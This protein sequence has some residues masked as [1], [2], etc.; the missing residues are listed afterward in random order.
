[1]KS[2][3]AATIALLAGNQY[4]FAELYTITLV[5]NTIL[6][7]TDGDGPITFGGNIFTC[8]APLISRS[9]LKIIVGVQADS[10]NVM[11]KVSQA[12]LINGITFPQFAAN[13]GFDGAKIQIDR[14]Y[15][16]TYGD[17]SAGVVNIFT[18]IV[19]DV[20]PSRTEVGL[21]VNSNLFL[22]NIAMP[23][24]VFSPGC[25]HIVY[26][27]GCGAVKA[28]FGAG[29]A[30]TSGSTTSQINCGL[31]QASGWF[32]NGSISFT[33][34]VNSGAIR[35]IKSYTPGVILLA[36]PLL[37]APTN[38]DAF[39]AYAGCDK[40]YNTCVNKFN[41]LVSF[42]GFPYIPIPESSV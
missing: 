21:V 5:D 9:R 28:S 23:R 37:N 13:G 12:N 40:S 27:A 17:T 35:T 3:S 22:L 20:L 16:A 42:R 24:N 8:N 11:M 15:M 4:L 25:S 6:R 34:G 30:V 39:T 36:M 2:A 31:A 19:T 14:C 32:D 33:S 26:D 29:S 38:G 7:Y 1:M 10:V 41:R 18:G